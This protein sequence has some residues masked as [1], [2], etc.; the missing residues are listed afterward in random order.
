[1]RTYNIFFLARVTDEIN[2]GDNCNVGGGKKGIAFKKCCYSLFLDPKDNT[3]GK[4]TDEKKKGIFLAR[5]V[6]R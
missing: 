4:Q 2:L 3:K 6:F 1:M 5:N